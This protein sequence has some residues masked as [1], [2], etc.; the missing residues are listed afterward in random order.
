[1]PLYAFRLNSAIWESTGLAAD[2]LRNRVFE[3][4]LGDLKQ[5]N[6][7]AEEDSFRKF[8]FRY[9]YGAIWFNGTPVCFTSFC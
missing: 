2:G 6:K 8:R 4:N 9:E 7:G 1:L 5:D 3:M